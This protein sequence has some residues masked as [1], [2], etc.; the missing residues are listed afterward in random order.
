[1]SKD[2]VLIIGASS[3]IGI[4]LIQN[5]DEEFQDILKIKTHYEQIFT[6]KGHN[7]HYLKFRPYAV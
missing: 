2:I 7:I 6:E 5:F 1:M 3:D 4:D